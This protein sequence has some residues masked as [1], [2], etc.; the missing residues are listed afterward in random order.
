[1]AEGDLHVTRD[2]DAGTITVGEELARVILVEGGEVVAQVV[3]IVGPVTA[4]LPPANPPP[5]R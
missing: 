4:D 1:M 3:V 5:R 2:H